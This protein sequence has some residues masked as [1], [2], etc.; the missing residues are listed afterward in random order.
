MR[1]ATK[2]GA[3]KA[4][5]QA[6][7]QVQQS[8]EA[9]GGPL[10][11]VGSGDTLIGLVREQASAQGLTLSGPQEMRLAQRVA[12][13]NGIQNANRIFTGQ[14]IS[15]GALQPEFQAMLRTEPAATATAAASAAEATP[16]AAAIATSAASAPAAAPPM[17]ATSGPH[18]VLEKTLE[19]AVTKGFI[20]VAE[21]AAVH[22]KILQLAS[23]HRFAPDDFARMTLMESDGMNPRSSNQRCHG[24]IQFCDG[25]DRGAASVGYRSNPNKNQGPAG[26]EDLYLSVLNPASRSEP[27]ASA[28]LNIPGPQASSLHVGRDT[29]API[30]RQSIRQGLV[31]NA[32]ERLAQIA[33]PVMRMQG[34]RAARY[35]ESSFK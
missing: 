11:T 34:L 31:Q 16:A 6:L 23:T 33:A 14:K 35:D 12:S 17:A 29:S 10:R 22:E 2:V 21:K 32:S 18:P 1:D 30:T 8:A 9:K 5:S 4:F 26:L 27:Q 13:D 20:P 24:I 15:L 7:G 19:R 25:P 28:P 3:P